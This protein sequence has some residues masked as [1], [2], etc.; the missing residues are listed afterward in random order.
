MELV[1][2]ALDATGKATRDVHAAAA[3]IRRSEPE[4]VVGAVTPSPSA[5]ASPLAAAHAALL[6][7]H[8]ARFV[9]VAGAKPSQT[10]FE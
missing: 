2:P 6:E 5:P 8:R 10:R 4:V 1:D 9:D 3:F 7:I